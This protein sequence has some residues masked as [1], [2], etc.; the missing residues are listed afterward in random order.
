MF[1]C[2]KVYCE[3]VCECPTNENMAAFQIGCN[4]TGDTIYLVCQRD[5]DINALAGWLT[6]VICKDCTSN[7]L[8]K[9]ASLTNLVTENMAF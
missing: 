6:D 4:K 1:L 8:V 7:F 3:E 9:N 2:D 5:A